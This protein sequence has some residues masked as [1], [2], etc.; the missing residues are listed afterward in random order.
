MFGEVIS[1]KPQTPPDKLVV[2][3]LKP[4]DFTTPEAIEQYTK[5]QQANGHP[6]LLVTK[7]GFL[8]NPSVPFLGASP[9]GAV[10]DPSN[11]DQPFGFLEVKCPY[12]ARNMTPLKG[13][14]NAS[15][16]C[17]DGKLIL[18]RQHAYFAQV[19]GHWRT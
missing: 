15:F 18:K 6:A 19:Q 3:I 10:Y 11:S 5:Y 14:A 9:D 1:R 7:S 4:T 12:S 2:W 16:C 13:A 17:S 8:V